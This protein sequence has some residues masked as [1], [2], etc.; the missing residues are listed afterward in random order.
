MFG[1]QQ[2]LLPNVSWTVSVYAA[3]YRGY[4]DGDRDE[5]GD[6]DGDGEGGVSGSW[7]SRFR[8]GGPDKGCGYLWR[9]S[10]RR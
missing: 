5:D 4:D 10:R 2:M 6:G 3:L 9:H 8:Q 7:G 1:K